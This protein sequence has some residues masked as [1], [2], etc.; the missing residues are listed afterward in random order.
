M[1]PTTQKLLEELRTSEVTKE[2]TLLTAPQAA[3]NLQE[4]QEQRAFATDIADLCNAEEVR[5]LLRIKEFCLF[6]HRQS[7]MGAI[8]CGN[9]PDYEIVLTSEQLL[10][11][12][13]GKVTESYQLPAPVTVW[14]KVLPYDGECHDSSCGDYSFPDENY[15]ESLQQRIRSLR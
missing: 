4:R 11:R 10:V 3:Y 14:E 13:Y 8:M 6:S 12:R 15:V 1:K 9:P 5:S 7:S 2:Y